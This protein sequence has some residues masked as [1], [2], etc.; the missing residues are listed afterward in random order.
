MTVEEGLKQSEKA[1]EK[2]IEGYAMMSDA[3]VNS[4]LFSWQWW[5][6]A[7]LII[8]PWIFWFIFRKKES[9]GRLLF[10]GFVTILLA[11]IIDLIAVSLGLWSYPMKFF[12]IS[13]QLFLPYHFSLAPV[14]VMV[15]LQIK[16]RANPLLKGIIFSAIAAF[17]GMNVF[18]MLNF[19]NP[20]GWPT[21]YDFVIYLFL[22]FIAYWVSKINSFKK[23]DEAD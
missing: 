21:Y 11:I 17:V 9:T 14:A 6:G 5:L 20:K 12:P 15:T 2:L 10:A 4:F 18:D 3:V 7:G 22:Y 16:P 23:L 1:N 13:P 19:Y 8:L